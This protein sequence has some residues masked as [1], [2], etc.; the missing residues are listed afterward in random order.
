MNFARISACEAGLLSEEEFDQAFDRQLEYDQGKT[1]ESWSRMEV[2]DVTYALV[3]TAIGAGVLSLPYA[4]AQSGLIIGTLILLGIGVLSSYSGELLIEASKRTET[5]S[6]G[7]LARATCGAWAEMMTSACIA[8]TTWLVMGSYM[9]VMAD[10]MVPVLEWIIP[11][12]TVFVGGYWAFRLWIQVLSLLVILPYCLRDNMSGFKWIAVLSIVAMLALTAAVVLL[13]VIRIIEQPVQWTSHV[14]SSET[15]SAVSVKYFSGTSSFIAISI[16]SVSYLCH[17]NIPPIVAKEMRAPT[18]KRANEAI[19]WSMVSVAIMY[20][21][22]A[23]FGYIYAYDMPGGV[24]G[25]ILLSFPSDSLVVNIVRVGLYLTLDLSYPLLVLPCYQSLQSL[26]GGLRGDA[27]HRSGGIGSKLWSVAEILLLCI[28]S[29]A[30]AI[31]VPHIQVVF[32]FLGSTVCN[33]ITFVLPP[34]FFVNSRPAG[35][36][37]WTK[38]NAAPVALFAL[39]IL[40]V[41]ACTG[42]QIA[43]I[44]QLVS[45]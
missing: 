41:V 33:I 6:Y 34:L 21:A 38:R 31:A 13:S 22:F 3:C 37:L 20:V 16:S 12:I 2:K 9:I 39:G 19:R 1:K 25:D 35:S 44:D 26:L 11:G 15:V 30:C 5:I 24:S 18:K 29:L 23:V 8:L 40:L 7:A 17:F 43:N 14:Q 45:K 28:T 32:A 10:M 36:T 4:M 42:V 27:N